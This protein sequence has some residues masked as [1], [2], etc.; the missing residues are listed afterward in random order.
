MPTIPIEIMISEEI[1]SFEN[2]YN[3]P[4]KVALRDNDILDWLPQAPIYIFHGI[5]DE[6]VPYENSLLAYDQFISNNVEN[7]YLEILPESYGGHQD[8]APWALLGAFNFAEQYQLIDCLDQLDCNGICGGNAQLDICG[9]C[10]GYN[11]NCTLGDVNLDDFLNV[12]DIVIITS[13]IFD[14]NFDALA[15]L[16]SDSNIN[17]FDL[18]LLI[19]LIINE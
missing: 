10:N 14:E 19:E 5:S 6:L 3:H 7:V 17:I 13:L 15:D 16:N 4:L 12:L 8:A 9:E 18:I 2:D 1:E 11:D